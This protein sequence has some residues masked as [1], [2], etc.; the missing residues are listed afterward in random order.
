MA[1]VPTTNQLK[2]AR[3]IESLTQRQVATEAGLSQ[4]VISKIENGK[5]VKWQQRLALRKIYSRRGIAFPTNGSMPIKTDV[6]VFV[7]DQEPE[8]ATS[9]NK[10][11]FE[12]D[13]LTKC[14]QKGKLDS[15]NE[16]V[17]PISRFRFARSLLESSRAKN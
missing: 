8:I 5:R 15:R 13:A 4:T 16:T 11:K 6:G 10:R 3:Q 12:L 7:S 14:L 1:Y 2:L 9:S 17:L